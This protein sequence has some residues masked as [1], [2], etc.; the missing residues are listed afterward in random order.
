ML[1]LGRSGCAL[2][3]DRGNSAAFAMRTRAHEPE[4]ASGGRRFRIGCRHRA[5]VGAAFR[6]SRAPAV[7][8]PTARPRTAA[9]CFLP[10]RSD[11][12]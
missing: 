10:S 1:V 8:A 3:L 6:H 7:I 12:T 4:N 9:A 11:M 5:A 2:K